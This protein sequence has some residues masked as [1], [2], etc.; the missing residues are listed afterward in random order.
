MPDSVHSTVVNPTEIMVDSVNSP[1]VDDVNEEVLLPTPVAT[2]KSPR[3]I[4]NSQNLLTL[5][6]KPLHV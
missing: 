2:V 4:F 1:D 5:K 3:S 6:G